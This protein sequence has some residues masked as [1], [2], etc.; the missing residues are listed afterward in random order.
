VEIEGITVDEGGEEI[1]RKKGKKKRK[2]YK[3]KNQF[4]VKI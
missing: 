4:T 1:A 2:Q 3:L